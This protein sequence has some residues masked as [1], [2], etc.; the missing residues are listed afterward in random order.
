M[1][2][3]TFTKNQKL[4]ILLLC[5]CIFA[6]TK[7]NAQT[8]VSTLNLLPGVKI[9]YNIGSGLDFGAHLGFTFFNYTISRTESGAGI[10]IAYDYFFGHTYL[11]GKKRT[12]FKTIG[13]SL[14][15]NTNNQV[16]AKLGLSKTSVK[17]G[18]DNRNKSESKSWGYSADL[19]YAPLK[20]GLFI[21]YHIFQVN[22]ACMG[23]G[24]NHSNILY[25]GYRYP[26][27]IV[28]KNPM[29]VNFPNQ[30]K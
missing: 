3:E 28:L 6:P 5:M 29:A 16:V 15:N 22:N 20:N 14:L 1:M 10:D 18:F 17:W 11:R 21:G 8:S 25:C 9:G 23:L 24:V 7:T 27:S 26:I 19:C 4:F 13:I 30:N 2:G 12:V